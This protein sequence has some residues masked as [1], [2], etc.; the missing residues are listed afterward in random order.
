[1]GLLEKLFGKR[2][3]LSE[4]LERGALI[5]DVRSEGEFAG[6]HVKGSTNIP[7]GYIKEEA[8]NIKAMEKPII[9]C[10]ASGMRSGMAVSTLKR[11]GIEAY[12]GGSWNNVNRLV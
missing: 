6:G 2:V 3:D 8:Q 4:V 9:L 10:C 1:M 12:N 5:I 7:L 11:A